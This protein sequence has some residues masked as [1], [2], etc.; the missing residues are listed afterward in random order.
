MDNANPEKEIEIAILASPEATLS[1]VYGMNDLLSSPGRDW[2]LITEGR[3]GKSLIKPTIVTLTGEETP[4]VNHG[5]L[6]PHR[7]LSADYQPDAVCVLEIFTDPTL[8]IDQQY[9]EEIAWLKRYWEQGGII[10][11]ACTGALLLAESG[12]L[13]GKEATT[14]WGFCNS[15][16]E[17][18]PEIQI[19]SNRAFVTTGDEQRLIMAGGGTTW[20]D[21]GLYLIAKFV[22]VDEAIKVAKLHLIEWHQS[23]QQAYAYL[24]NKRQYDDAEIAQSQ[25]WLSNHYDQT[26]PVNTAIEKSGLNERTFV[27][28]FKNATGMT[29]MEYVLNLRIEEAKQMLETSNM[30]IDAI[31]ENVGYQDSSFFNRKF[32]QKVGLSPAK[33]RRK[34]SSLRVLLS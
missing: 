19:Q 33:Y 27:R 9:K 26:S 21:L 1:T 34:F 28:R 8:G 14:H 5:W 7:A 16:A 13:N 15:M 11:T 22:D 25:V 32:Q 18:Y 20:M 10:A 29:P 2:S 30:S 31:A 24:C 6:K 3:L 17:R 4:C 12:I 23:G